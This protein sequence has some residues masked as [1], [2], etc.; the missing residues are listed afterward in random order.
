MAGNGQPENP[1]LKREGLD[2]AVILTFVIVGAIGF[3]ILLHFWHSGFAALVALLI[4]LVAALIQWNLL[5]R[6]I[7]FN[8][9]KLA[10]LWLSCEERLSSLHVDLKKMEKQGDN[11][12]SELPAGVYRVREALLDA[13]QRADK[14][15]SQL[16]NFAKENSR[17]AP[18][19]SSLNAV[20]DTQARELLKVAERNMAE[21]RLTVAAVKGGVDRTEAQA[22]VFITTLDNLR[23][24]MMG[25]QLK[26]H[27][28]ESPSFEFLSSIAEIKLQ[29]ESIDK[30]LDELDLSLYPKT[31]SVVNPGTA[32]IPP[33]FGTLSVQESHET[34]DQ[35]IIEPVKEPDFQ[36]RGSIFVNLIDPKEPGVKSEQDAE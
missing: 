4:G 28:T 24:R 15:I 33:D 32:S 25:Y 26:G 8:S 23:A 31:I 5:K 3:V 2:R 9:P 12:V 1:Y 6:G 34:I 10:A 7:K 13:F 27:L 18:V 20:K 22:L 36:P 29:L 16:D 35:S 11:F 19:E 14:V 17:F 21:Y 30:A